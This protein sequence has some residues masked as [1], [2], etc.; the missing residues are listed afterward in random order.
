MTL[1]RG[2]GTNRF[3]QPVVVGRAM[4]SSFQRREAGRVGRRVACPP[5]ANSETAANAAVPQAGS[6]RGIA[7]I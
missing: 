1:G 3:P 2:R 7:R 6:H 5:I 4:G